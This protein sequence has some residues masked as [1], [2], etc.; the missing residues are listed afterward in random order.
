M[1]RIKISKSTVDKL[2]LPRIGQLIYRD[3]QLTGFGI[4][5]GTKIKA[6]FCQK[7]IAGQ[8]VRFTIGSHGQITAEQA[9]KMAVQTLAD[10]T[11]GINPVEAKRADRN[12]RVTLGQAFEDYLNNRKNL[13]EKTIYDYKNCFKVCFKTWHSKPITGI[14]K[15]MVEKRHKKIG[16]ERGHAYANFSMRILRAIFN[17][18]MEKYE[19]STGK[20]LIYEN[21]IKRITRTRGWYRIEKRDDR[22]TQQELPDFFEAVEKL[23]NETIRDYFLVLLFTGLRR[24]EAARIKWDDI[25]FKNRT[26]SMPDTKNNRK[27]TLPL[28]TFLYDL[29]KR[30]ENHGS[31]WVFPSNSR[32][33]YIKDPRR[34]LARLLT[35]SGLKFTIHGLRRTF[36]GI[37]KTLKIYPDDIKELMN[38]SLGGDMTAYYAGKDVE[39]LRKPMQ[40]IT[41]FILMN[42][43]RK[44]DTKVVGLHSRSI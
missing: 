37:G 35:L 23:E 9:R 11:K 24:E 27:L 21:P 26:F 39:R 29:F 7:K 44:S 14:S 32:D 30:R 17:F 38:H 31:G 10:M 15:D 8:V 16:E 5:V 33:G 36:A 19:D 20:P 12:D 22:I 3:T 40:K 42:A 25:S 28:S 4:R 41:D 1:N 18:G 34:Q 43:N 2:P 6:Y 13:K